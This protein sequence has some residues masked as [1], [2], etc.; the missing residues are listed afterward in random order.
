MYIQFPFV[1]SQVAIH[2]RHP[3]IKEVANAD[4]FWKTG[5]VQMLNPNS[6]SSINILFHCLVNIFIFSVINI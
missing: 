5:V 6:F 3:Q 2:K 1:E 4:S